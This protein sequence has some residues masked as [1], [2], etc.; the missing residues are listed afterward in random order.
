MRL[1]LLFFGEFA[2]CSTASG[3]QWGEHMK[4]GF[5]KNDWF[6]GLVVLVA[7]AVFNNFSDLIPSLE[8]KAYD[9]GV[10]ATSRTP[11]P[12]VIVIAIDETSIANIGRWPWQRDVLA[13]MTD[14]LSGAKVKVIDSA[15]LLSGPQL[16]KGYQYVSK[17]IE[18]APPD[19]PKAAILREAE[20]ELNTDR[21]LAQS[22]A[23]AGNVLMPMDFVL[24]TPLGKPG[25]PLP[26]YVLK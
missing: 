17:L 22:Y 13:K 11:N 20:Q 5:W 18:L 16:D 24:G 23:R 15:I 25:K 19:S 14:I 4:S 9:L 3:Q 2:A 12:D 8:H 21:K 7:F 1:R 10:S 6:L 26:E